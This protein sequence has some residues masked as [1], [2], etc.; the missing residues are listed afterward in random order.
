MSR[1]E[2]CAALGRAVGFFALVLSAAPVS[3]I[4]IDV[5]ADYATIQAAIVAA[6]DSDEIVVAAGT[7]NERIDFLGKAITVR[8]SNGAA[9]TVID[10]GAAG[11]VV[12]F[13]TG[14][15]SSAV[16]DGF[17]IRN[18]RTTNADGAGIYVSSASPT[19]VNNIITDNHAQGYGS[20]IAVNLGSPVIQNNVIRNNSP[21][22]GL[23]GGGGG[24]GIYIGG[25]GS[26]QVIGNTI[27]DNTVLPGFLSGG[28][29][30]L[31]AAGTPTLRNNFIARNRARIG[32][33]IALA[34][35]SD[36]LIVQNIIVGNSGSDHGGGIDWV[37]PDGDRGPYV[38]NN[39][40]VG[41]GSPL[42]SQIHA[43]GFDAST[44][45]ANNVVVGGSTTGALIYCA[46]ATDQPAIGHND[47]YATGG[48]R[49]GGSC[50]D[51][52]GVNGNI[53]ADPLL[54]N[55][56]AAD[57][58][59]AP[60]SPA[61]DAGDNAAPDVPATDYA[62]TAR[63]VN[64][65]V[66]MGAYEY[67]PNPGTIRLAATSYTIHERIGALTVSV[68]RDG[69]DQG[70]VTVDYAT[71][72]G[73]ALAGP[74]YAASAGTLSFAAGDAAVKTF[75]VPIVNDAVVEPSEHF[76]V[77]L[78]APTGGAVLDDDY[79]VA[80][81]T[82]LGQTVTPPSSTGGGCFI[83]TAAY[84][85]PMAQDVRYLRALRD[86]YLLTNDAGRWFVKKYYEYSPALADGIREREWLK[87]V[88]RTVLAPLVAVSKALITP[89]ERDAQTA[90]RP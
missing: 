16:L 27:V 44:V 25:A 3:A 22:S 89:A 45:V 13:A 31:F 5:P 38:V 41:N 51:Q 74:D 36:A 14:E 82:I 23:S 9:S 7:Y 18:G 68:R 11:R 30:D 52:T 39:T 40:I 49:Y 77:V 62:G 60:G 80:T 59:L 33:G 32:G 20:G 4:T 70:A 73:T 87:P 55:V 37:V 35:Q 65:V 76:T 79:S 46:D 56:V 21:A 75:T 90:D 63:P 26:A 1:L 42:G 48:S 66:D 50:T 10:G 34:N 15:T 17:T 84:G 85:T 78:S 88:V 6:N 19:I 64:T 69:G 53:G 81:V 54:V 86:N 61:I 43:A 28:G 67:A 57:Y 47:V 12:T 72:D 2:T 29:I 58:R 83:A 24:G 71:S 8:S